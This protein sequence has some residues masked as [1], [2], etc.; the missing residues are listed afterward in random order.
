MEQQ[1][2]NTSKMFYQHEGL[3]I[4]SAKYNYQQA[5]ALFDG[6]KALQELSTYPFH[7]QRIGIILAR[8]VFVAGLEW[9]YLCICSGS[10]I[11]IKPPVGNLKF[12]QNLTQALQEHGIRISCTLEYNVLQNTDSIIAFGS[13]DSISN[14]TQQYENSYICGFGEKLSVAFCDDF[15]VLGKKCFRYIRFSGFGQKPA[16]V[17]CKKPAP[18]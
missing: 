14:I 2:Q 18:V 17:I 4:K 9:L 12:Y 1:N 13:N 15:P 6:A 3:S 8:G 7:P 16:P 5:I 11:I 10:E